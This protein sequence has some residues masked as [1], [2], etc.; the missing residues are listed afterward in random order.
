MRRVLSRVL[1]WTG[2]LLL[3]A[4]VA[5]GGLIGSR[6]G[7]PALIVALSQTAT[8]AD[9]Q[10]IAVATLRQTDS[11]FPLDEPTLMYATVDGRDLPDR[12]LTSV[13]HA[14]ITALPGSLAEAPSPTAFTADVHPFLI[15]PFGD[16]S[17][18]VF[19][20]CVPGCSKGW[21]FV[22]EKQHGQWTV[23]S[24]RLRWIA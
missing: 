11:P 12:L 15:S 21:H 5:L 23:V 22:L 20:H 10:D 16:A 9:M 8:P 24:K 17:G 7:Y 2:L 14:H 13:S 18:M 3:F 4:I 19:T 6:L 1:R